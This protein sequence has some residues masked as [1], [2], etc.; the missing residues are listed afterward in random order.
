LSRDLAHECIAV[1]I[2]VVIPTHNRRQ[3][4]VRCLESL[5][6]QTLQASDYEVIVVADGCTDGTQEYLR[7][8]QPPH[9]FRWLAQSN[10]GAAAAQNAGI[11][12]AVGDI[13]V[14]VD[15]DCIG[16]AEFLAVHQA[17]HARADR[18][19]AIGSLYLHPDS[20]GG[21]LR[22]LK[23][24]VWQQRVQRMSNEGAGRGDLMLC[25]NS[26]IRLD[27]L[28]HLVF[29][30]SYKRIH[31]VEAGARL[32][33]AGYRPHFAPKAVVYEL[34]TK[35]LRAVLSD[36]RQ[37]GKFEVVLA[38]SLPSFKPQAEIARFNEDG[39]LRRA[40][41]R[42]FAR[43][44]G[45]SEVLLWPMYTA[46]DALRALPPFSW[47][48]KRILGVRTRV[49][50][51]NGAI[52]EAGS[53]KKLEQRFFR[54]IPVIVYH[55]VGEPRPGE[56]PGLTTPLAEFAAQIHALASMGYKGVRPSEWL[57][58][59]NNGATLP[60]RPMIL[61]FDDAYAG[62]CH[63]AFP[64]LEQYGF[65]AACMAVTRCIGA[66]NR[67]DEEAGRPSYPMMS[68]S[69]IVEWSRRGIEFGGHTSHHRS[70]AHESADRVEQEVVECKE[71][72]TALLGQEPE[73]FAYPFGRVSPAALAAARRHFALAFTTRPGLL[74]LASD[75]HLVSRIGFLPGESRTGMRM[76]LRLGK[77]PYE[78]CRNRLSN[79]VDRFR[80]R[81]K[82]DAH[83]SC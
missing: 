2:S 32:W 82:T 43:H 53:W 80:G 62:A 15:D 41:L 31:D 42:R 27:A 81:N 13:L 40:L 68:A 16:D 28:P 38:N 24:Q 72:L 57:A 44:P 59:R 46:A 12:A 3:S 83:A 33:E 10:Q 75:P 50:L 1:K 58:W 14:F 70:L 78:V 17:V 65:A 63:H 47:L 61:V 67:W 11:A 7:A 45:A 64:I 5:A 36:C 6:A 52:R 51:L 29:D 56:Y 71:D 9:A 26:S 55:N 4:L 25:A 48:A 21:S 69:Q 18:V 30:S 8:H 54:R 34:D 77:N 19:V 76:R 37:Q 74:H 60:E 22:D 49:A 23:R 20:P 66:T 39:F 35:P 73:C 79:F